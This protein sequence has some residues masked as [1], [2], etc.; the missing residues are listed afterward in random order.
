[1]TTLAIIMGLACALGCEKS[2]KKDAMPPAQESGRGIEVEAPGVDVKVRP[3]EGI[4]V[5]APGADVKVD[6]DEPK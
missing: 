6:A 1:M 4:D 5:E 2:A 3:G